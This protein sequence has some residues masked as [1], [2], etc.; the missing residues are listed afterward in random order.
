MPTVIDV[1][2]QWGRARQRDEA[3]AAADLAKATR[4][5]V[6][7]VNRLADKRLGI[8]DFYQQMMALGCSTHPGL[9]G[10][11]VCQKPTRWVHVYDGASL[12]AALR[13]FGLP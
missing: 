1:A 2:R 7:E 10:I 11:S 8:P 13:S 6:D 4:M 5:L 9:G 12:A 3:L